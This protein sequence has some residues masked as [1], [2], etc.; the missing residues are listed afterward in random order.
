MLAV[1]LGVL[2]RALERG[3][4]TRSGWPLIAMPLRAG[5]VYLLGG[6][7]A[8][9]QLLP[10]VELVRLSPRAAGASFAFVFERSKVGA[11]WLLLLFPYLFGAL[12]AGVYGEAPRI[13]TGVRIWEQAAYVGILPLALAVVG[14]AGLFVGRAP[15]AE[16][17][18][19]RRGTLAFLALLLCAGVVLAAGANTPFAEYTYA[20]PVLGRLRDVE[21][22]VVLASFALALLAGCGLQRLLDAGVATLADRWRAGL[23][24]LAVAIVAVPLGVVWLAARPTLSPELIERGITLETLQLLRPDRANA[25]VPLLLA[26]GSAEVLLAWCVAPPTATARRALALAAA[27]LVCCDLMLFAAAF[28]ATS[29]PAIRERI[30]PVAAFLR[31]DPGRF[32][33][34]VFLTNNDLDER[35]AQD[36]L[37]VSWGMVYGLQDINGFN[38]LQPRRYTDFLFGPDK[39]DVSYGYLRDQ[40]LLADDSPI[41]SA[42]NVKY[43]LVPRDAAPQ[44]YLGA[45][46]RP[47]W[48]DAAVRVYQNDRAYP[49]A[50]FAA[51]VFD[52]P[53]DPS[54]LATVTAPGFDGQ[55]EALVAGAGALGVSAAPLAPGETVAF[56]TYAPDRLALRA[57]TAAPRLLVLSE[58]D[59]PG[60]HATIDGQSVPI[61]RTNYLFRGIVVPPGQHTVVLTYRPASLRWGMIIS[62]LALVAVGSV[63]SLG[64]VAWRRRRTSG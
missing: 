58:M 33:T 6:A 3:V 27:A 15:S 30:S 13:G 47:V 5:G 44:P 8:A 42:L 22:S 37:A 4:A 32:R 46:F 31:Q 45:S 43:L 9:I 23:A 24:A 20:T 2:V 49:R 17:G 48:E 16:D 61:R 18:A 19:G 21:R 28:H 25:L 52:E 38:S 40:G 53:D 34:A 39:A 12:R 1:G 10:W 64:S 54:T 60:W 11:D 29:A 7:L 26:V 63:G 62:A 36:R 41:L 35:A 57:T 56:A 50:Y 59:F 55:R 14:L 51:R